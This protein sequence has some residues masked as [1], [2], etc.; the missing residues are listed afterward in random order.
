MLDRVGGRGTCT[1]VFGSISRIC[2]KMEVKTM[3]NLLIR[4]R[5]KPLNPVKLARMTEGWMKRIRALGYDMPFRM[6]KP[7]NGKAP[8][9]MPWFVRSEM[10]VV[11]GSDVVLCRTD[12]PEVLDIAEVTMLNERDVDGKPILGEVVSMSKVRHEGRSIV[13]SIKKEAQAVLGDVVW[14][15]VDF[16]LTD[17]PGKVTLKIFETEAPKCRRTTAL[18]ECMRRWPVPVVDAADAWRIAFEPFMEELNNTMIQPRYATRDPR[19]L[20]R[21]SD[22]QKI[23]METKDLQEELRCDNDYIRTRA[24]KPDRFN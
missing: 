2:Y 16:G 6:V 1:Q 19:N 23:M 12:V 13:I 22:V 9:P 14:R 8:L 21:V 5:V 4:E 17:F 15:F 11:V 3:Q 7:R 20:Q 10:N 18:P 24:E